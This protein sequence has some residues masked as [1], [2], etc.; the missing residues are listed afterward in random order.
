MKQGERD[1]IR[2]RRNVGM[3]MKTVLFT[4]LV[5]IGFGAKAWS[6]EE[7]HRT[8]AS[9]ALMS[10]GDAD[11]GSLDV[12]TPPPPDCSKCDFEFLDCAGGCPK[13]T[14]KVTRAIASA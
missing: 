12:T 7:T 11:S 4:L 9:T 3:R 13:G 10:G 8:A 14:R 6:G 5:V 1:G 2:K